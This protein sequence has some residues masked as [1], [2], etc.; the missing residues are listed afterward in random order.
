ML[1]GRV[2]IGAVLVENHCDTRDQFFLLSLLLKSLH[3]SKALLVELFVSALRRLLLAMDI[4]SKVS[5]DF[6]RFT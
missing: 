3:I 6:A 5:K 1:L 4:P 2:R